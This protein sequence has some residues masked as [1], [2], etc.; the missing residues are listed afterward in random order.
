MDGTLL[1]AGVSGKLLTVEQ[2][3]HPWELPNLTGKTL[4]ALF[5]SVPDHAVRHRHLVLFGMME[6][7]KTSLMNFLAAEARRRYS[8]QDVNII[9]AYS[10]R[11]AMDLIND[12]R[13]QLILIDDAIQEQNSRTSTKNAQ[14]TADFY[15]IRHTYEAMAG[16]RGGVV[17]TVWATQRFKSLD[18]V[19]R[20]GHILIFKTSAV[21]PEDDKLIR[22]YI[23][24]KAAG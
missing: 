8:Y 21:D 6:S 1:S 7:G 3:I 9:A 19:F 12:K 14:D 10:I 22:N 18:I 11:K 15:Q 20:Q 23:G 13:V 17:V 5:P 24:S 2:I 16:E 4:G